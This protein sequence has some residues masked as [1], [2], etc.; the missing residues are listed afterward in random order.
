MRKSVFQK[1]LD[2]LDEES[3]RE[4]LKTLYGKIEAVRKHYAM[5]LGSQKD[6]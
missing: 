1:H 2:Q 3:L 4:E 5:E 6:R